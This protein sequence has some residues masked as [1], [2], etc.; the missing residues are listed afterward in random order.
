MPAGPE[1]T[2][3]DTLAVHVGD[4][5]A[6]LAAV[7]P[8][9][10]EATTVR[11]ALLRNAAGV[12]PEHWSPLF[13]GWAVL[14]DGELA[15]ELLALLSEY[16]VVLPTDGNSFCTPHRLRRPLRSITHP[17]SRRART[18][19]WPTTPPRRDV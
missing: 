7:R 19:R 14:V 10:T 5:T 15:N 11:F 18:M 4:P 13:D 9:N 12:G 2:F 6:R 1:L 17:L 8:A 16:G 3:L